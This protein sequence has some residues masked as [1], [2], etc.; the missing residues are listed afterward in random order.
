VG[1][2]GKTTALAAPPEALGSLLPEPTWAHSDPG[3][4]RVG[5][6]LLRELADA[7]EL[8][9]F[10]R[11]SKAACL[12]R[13]GARIGSHTS[14]LNRV[15][16]FGS[17]PWLVEIGGRVSLAAGV[18]FITH[19]GSSR[20]FRHRIEGSSPFGNRFGTIRVL[21]NCVVGLRAILLPGVTVGPNSIVGAGSVVTRDV[22]PGTVAAGVPAR[23]LCTLDEYVERYRAAM[24]PGLASQRRELRRQLTRRLW[25]EER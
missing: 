17:E 5:R 2:S 20:V 9:F 12:R 25:G 18:A 7:F 11:G 23:V 16:D 21:D 22:P 19:D 24:I 3:T 4:G 15:K 1:S 14:I 8:W 10:C 6:R 13:R